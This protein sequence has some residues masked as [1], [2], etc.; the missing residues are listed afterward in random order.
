[1]YIM[2]NS[3]RYEF[4]ITIDCR[5][6]IRHGFWKRRIQKQHSTISPSSLV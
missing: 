2:Y 5:V 4:K 6:N 3:T 1:M